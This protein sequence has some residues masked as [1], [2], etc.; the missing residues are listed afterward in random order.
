MKTNGTPRLS[1]NEAGNYEIRWTENRVTKRVSCHTRDKAQAEEMLARHILKASATPVK[2]TSVANILSRYLTEYVEDR[3]V[4]K[5]RQED[6]INV[7][8]TGLQQYD[9]HELSPVVM[10][11]YRERRKAGQI[12][13]RKVKDGTLRRELNCLVAA[14]SHSRKHHGLTNA[15]TIILPDAPPPKDIW[16]TQA[17]LGQLVMASSDFLGSMSRVHRFV[18]IAANTA[19]RKGSILELRWSQ[20]DFASGII[21]FQNDGNRRTKKRRVPVPISDALREVLTASHEAR[22]QDE[23]VLDTPYSIQHHFDAVKELAFEKTGNAKF[24]V[25]TPHSIRH[26][27]ATLAAQAGVPLFEVAGVLGDTLSTVTRVYAHHC[28]EHLRSAVNFLSSPSA[29]QERRQ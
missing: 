29:Q 26:T 11:D 17:E 24:K 12:N 13:G 21:N 6:C 9:V 18:L 19:A 15:P 2:A 22:T 20:V 14:I 25:I 8:L 23:W 3:V 5:D 10:R 1:T 7:L 16:M 4:D 28:P 27:W